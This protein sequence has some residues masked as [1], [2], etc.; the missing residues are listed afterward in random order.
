MPT[1]IEIFRA[2]AAAGS[3]S[4]SEMLSTT[5][6]TEVMSPLSNAETDD[7]GIYV[8]IDGIGNAPMV[9][10][11]PLT[12]MTGHFKLNVKKLDQK[13]LLT[14]TS[15]MEISW[16]FKINADYMDFIAAL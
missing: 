8:A 7:S 1:L 9:T 5:V 10:Q 15:V 13:R 14:Q 11:Y 3:A 12:R 6:S 4:W 16:I 2:C